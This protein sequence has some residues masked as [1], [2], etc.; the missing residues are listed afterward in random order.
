MIILKFVIQF[1]SQ[2]QFSRHDILYEFFCYLI[3][4]FFIYF[5][6]LMEIPHD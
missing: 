4:E 6:L 1:V 3:C 2:L 5:I